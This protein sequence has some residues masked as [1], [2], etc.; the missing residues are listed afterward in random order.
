MK[1]GAWLVAPFE[2]SLAFP[3]DPEGLWERALSRL[4]VQPGAVSATP[5]S[6]H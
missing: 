6:V 3:V 2:E 4:G 1:E 5:S